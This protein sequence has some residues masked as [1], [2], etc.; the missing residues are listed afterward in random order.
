MFWRLWCKLSRCD[1]AIVREVLDGSDFRQRWQVGDASDLT[2]T[3]FA[4][5]ERYAAK[6]QSLDPASRSNVQLQK[7]LWKTATGLEDS[8]MARTAVENLPVAKGDGHAGGNT[9]GRTHASWASK[10][11][12]HV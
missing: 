10:V 7:D 3:A 11:P 4:Q 2:R 1:G 6:G 12:S 8:G 9:G 5:L